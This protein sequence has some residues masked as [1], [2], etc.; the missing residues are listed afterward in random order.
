MQ[1]LS[2]STSDHCPMLVTCNP[3]HRNFTGFRFEPYWLHLPGFAETVVDS[4]TKPFSSADK[5]RV[6]HVKLARLGKAL[7]KW[8]RSMVEEKKLRTEIAQEV[9]LRLDQAQERRPL[10]PGELSLRKRAKQRILGFAALRRIKIRQRSRLTWIREGDAITRIPSSSI[11]ELRR[12]GE[13]NYIPAFR[14]ANG[15]VTAHHDKV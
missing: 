11:L 5:I 2:T 9:V 6:L 7:K 8:S 13:K 4:W 3:F 10:T 12:A 14:T 1:A 15:M